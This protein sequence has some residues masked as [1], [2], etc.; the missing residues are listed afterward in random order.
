MRKQRFASDASHELRTVLA[1]LRA[2]LE[3]A[4]LHPEETDLGDLLAGALRNVER[5]DSILTDLRVIAEMEAG[6]PHELQ[7]VDLAELVREEI[8]GR[9]DRIPVQLRIEAGATITAVPIRISRVLTNLLNNAQR[10]ARHLIEVRLVHDGDC[11][12]LTVIDD[13]EG[14]AES[15]RERIFERFTRLDAARRLDRTGA[16]LGLA[17]AR[18]I[19]EAHLGSLHVQRA[20]TGGACFVL[21]LPL[22]DA[23]APAGRRAGTAVDP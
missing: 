14:V 5:L 18:D 10:H 13:G 6:P 17:I 15:Q 3:E 2:E 20:V 4:R 1:G 7:R 8:V 21:R 12:E 22:A 9:A 19:A 11:A 16:G 23:A